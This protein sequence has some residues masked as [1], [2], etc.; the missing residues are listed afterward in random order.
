MK[1]QYTILALAAITM[2]I[3]AAMKKGPGKPEK[4][5]ESITAADLRTHLSILASDEYEGRETGE[6]GQKMAAEYIS[7]FFQKIGAPAQADGSWYQQVKLIKISGGTSNIE[8][9]TNGGQTKFSTETDYYYAASTPGC[10]ITT[11][12]FYFAGYGIDDPKYSDFK[13]HDSAFYN[14]KILIVLDGE[15]QNGGVFTISGDGQAGKWSK[16][17]RLKIENAKAYKAKAMIIVPLDF[18]KSKEMAQ[19]MIQGY[20]LLLDEPGAGADPN[21]PV[22]YMS[23]AAANTIL[24]A[25]GEKQTIAD[26][27]SG[28]NSTGKASGLSIKT[29]GTISVTRNE[30]KVLTENVLAYVEGTDLK[31]QLIVVTGHYDHLG[32]HDGKVFNGADDDGSGTVAVMELA[33]A[34]MKAKQDGAGPRRSMLFMTVTGEEK[35]LLGSAWYV[36]HPVYPLEKTMCDLNIDMIGRVDD[37]HKNDSNFVYVIGSDKISPDLKKSIESANKKY[38]HLKLDYRF[39]DPNDPNGFYYRSDHYNF[40]K[41]GIPVAFFFNGVHEDYHKETDEVS[42]IN[43]SLMQK[44]TRLV[45]YAAWDLA[46]RNKPLARKAVKK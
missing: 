42:R 29:T 30:E 14:G 5:A 28:I 2:L 45:F 22:F 44:R 7:N 20:S 9:A 17:R 21:P 33:E 32:K 35:G 23:E 31:E 24:A 36:R 34:F 18:V 40:A 26:L 1:K 4:Y 10:A 3:S 12:E 11:N 27:K 41:N 15:P 38:S 6:K 46:N 39:D 19:H 37:E 8:I 25:G 43:F 16:Q 13:A